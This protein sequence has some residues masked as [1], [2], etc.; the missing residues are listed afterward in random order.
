[1][2]ECHATGEDQELQPNPFVLARSALDTAN[3]GAVG[4]F[5]GKPRQARDEYGQRMRC[6]ILWCHGRAGGFAS[7]TQYPKSSLIKGTALRIGRAESS[8]AH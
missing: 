2:N 7:P 5:S 3:Q 8:P 1:M 6:G 4:T